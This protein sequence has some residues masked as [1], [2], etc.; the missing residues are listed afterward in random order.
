MK[1]MSHG[2]LENL[3]SF[4]LICKLLPYCLVAVASCRKKI[5]QTKSLKNQTVLN[6]KSIWGMLSTFIGYT[7][8]H[9][10]DNRG[11]NKNDI[12]SEIWSKSYINYYFF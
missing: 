6:A 9:F 5:V 7:N 11:I 1:I 2:F 8:Y 3:N 4:Y 10:I 12:F